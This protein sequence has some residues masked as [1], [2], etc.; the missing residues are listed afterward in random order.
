MNE[1]IDINLMIPSLPAQM[2]ES[3][4]GVVVTV[5]MLTEAARAGNLE[6]LASWARQGVR[7]TTA[8]PLYFATRRGHLE[9]LRCL[10]QELGADVN[11][12]Q[13]G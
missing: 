7:V 8:R 2:A 12:A 6:R 9:V 3:N 1:R 5:G 4:D 13:Y 10:V 11:Q